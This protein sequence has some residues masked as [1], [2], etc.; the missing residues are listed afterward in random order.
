MFNPGKLKF[1]YWQKMD[2]SKV[3]ATEKAHNNHYWSILDDSMT[4]D[5]EME[6]AGYEFDLDIDIKK[7]W[8]ECAGKEVNLDDEFDLEE[9]W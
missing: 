1:E 8:N 7:G 2:V 6:C 5:G 4:K 3:D 9:M